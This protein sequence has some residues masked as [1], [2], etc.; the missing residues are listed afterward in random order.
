MTMIYISAPPSPYRHSYT[1][2]NAQVVHL[3]RE[4]GGR[5]VVEGHG[6]TRVVPAPSPAPDSLETWSSYVRWHYPLAIH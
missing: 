4:G 3:A 5:A 6:L 2:R 1:S